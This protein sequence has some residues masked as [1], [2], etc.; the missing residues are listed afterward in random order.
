MTFI[1]PSSAAIAAPA[2]P[3]TTIAVMTGASSMT[4]AKETTVPTNNG[5]L[6]K[7]FEDAPV[8]SASTMPVKKAVIAVTGRDSTPTRTIW[9]KVWRHSM[10]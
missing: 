9:I 8:C 2:R 6:K 7:C 1:V 3:A 4:R 10:R 5:S